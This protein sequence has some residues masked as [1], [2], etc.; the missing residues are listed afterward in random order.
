VK[1]ATRETQLFCDFQYKQSRR[2]PEKLP[3]RLARRA[4][5]HIA[6]VAL[7]RR[8]SRITRQYLGTRLEALTLT[9][10]TEELEGIYIWQSRTE[11]SGRDHL[12]RHFVCRGIPGISGR[13]CHMQAEGSENGKAV[14]T[15]NGYSSEVRADPE[16]DQDELGDRCQSALQVELSD[17]RW[18]QPKHDQ[19]S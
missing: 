3:R 17:Q 6:R 2:H 15:P 1:A 4:T 11:L 5:S 13:V 9:W 8:R 12:Q 14:N 7:T 10:T 18:Q 16:Y 19:Y